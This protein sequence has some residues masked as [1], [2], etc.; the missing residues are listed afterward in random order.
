MNRALFF[1]KCLHP[2]ADRT[3]DAPV[4]WKIQKFFK[5][6]ARR[7]NETTVSSIVSHRM[8]VVVVG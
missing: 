5:I 1:K 6:T 4:D 7:I 2:W 8:V 3:N